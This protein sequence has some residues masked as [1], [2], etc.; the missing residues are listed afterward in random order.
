MK[1]IFMQDVKGS[2]KKGEVKEV[3]DGYARNF[4]ITKGLA[5]EAT[6]KNLSD[7][8]GKQSSAQHKIDVDKENANNIAA[9]INEKTVKIPAKAGSAGKLF[10]AVTSGQIADAIQEQF[11]QKVDKKKISLKS[12]IKNFGTYEADIKLYNGISAKMT[13]EVTEE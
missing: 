5:V 2:G 10:G 13:V 7:L 12:E 9:V 3:S 8:A 1:V 11:G 4:L 6:N